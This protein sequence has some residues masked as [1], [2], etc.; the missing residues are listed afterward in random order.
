MDS[1]RQFAF[2]VTFTPAVLARAKALAESSPL[3][4][5]EELLE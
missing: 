5:P 3:P 2:A 4:S 1:L